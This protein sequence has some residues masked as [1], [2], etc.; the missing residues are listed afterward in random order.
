M[1]VNIYLV[2]LGVGKTALVH[3]ICH[4]Y[5]QA[6]I[7]HSITTSPGASSDLERRQTIGC[8]VEV[9]VRVY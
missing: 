8:H 9:K 2:L 7:R 6:H 5:D 1:K 4:S 3:N